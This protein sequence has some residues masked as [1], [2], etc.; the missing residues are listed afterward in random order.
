MLKKIVFLKRS[1]PSHPPGYRAIK[2]LF[3]FFSL[4]IVGKLDEIHPFYSCGYNE[5]MKTTEA[6]LLPLI[7]IAFT[8]AII[9]SVLSHLRAKGLEER[10]NILHGLLEKCSRTIQ[11]A[12]Q[13]LNDANVRIENL[14]QKDHQTGV[15]NKR[16]FNEFLDREWRLAIRMA[17]PVSL[18][19][20]DIDSLEEGERK[21]GAEVEEKALKRIAEALSKTT[22]RPGDL[23]GRLNSKEFAVVLAFTPLEAAMQ[24][25]EKLRATIADLEVNEENPEEF[26]NI[27]INVGIAATVPTMGSKPDELI[28]KA[29]KALGIAKMENKN[30]PLTVH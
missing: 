20:I 12:N 8:I 24:V 23:A 17:H 9:V 16:Y 15:A 18:M 4:F 11:D 30:E 3:L 19:I 29:D 22:N 26:K 5:R 14:E 27:L 1:F 25:A 2:G 21:L 6:S 7:L 10:L 13:R 28:A